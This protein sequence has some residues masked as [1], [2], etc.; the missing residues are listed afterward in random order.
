MS[1]K[2]LIS[3]VFETDFIYLALEHRC[4]L[5]ELV[6]SFDMNLLTNSTF[7]QLMYHLPLSFQYLHLLIE[8]Q[9]KSL[10]SPQLMALFS[11]SSQINVKGARLLLMNSA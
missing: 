10:D 5:P 4:C 7:I 6:V 3:D 9:A 2:V 11:Y 8:L 1:L